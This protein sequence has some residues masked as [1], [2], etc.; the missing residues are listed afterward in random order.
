MRNSKKDR[1]F[2]ESFWAPF[3]IAL[4]CT[5]LIMIRTQRVLPGHPDFDKPEDHHKYI[6]MAQKGPFQFHIAPY[7]WRV[8]VPL[9]A[10]WLPFELSSN[11]SAIS[12]FGVWSAGVGIWYLVKA[13]GYG[14]ALRFFALFLYY[15]I[16][17]S[18]RFPIMDPW[19]P[20][21]LAMGV[22][23]WALVCLLTG[24]Y[25]LLV[26]LLMLGASI[27]ESTIF[28]APLCFTF[29]PRATCRMRD[30]A[31]NTLTFLPAIL[32]LIVLRLAIPAYNADANYREAV[33]PRLYEVDNP[34][35]TGISP[36]INKSY[37][38]LTRLRLIG[39][40]R[41][42][43]LSIYTV[44]ELTVGTF[45]LLPV[46]LILWKLGSQMQLLA[47]WSPFLLC[48]YSQILFATETMRLLAIAFP[49]IIVLSLSGALA[50]AH[51]LRVPMHYLN[52]LP[53]AIFSLSLIWQ[54]RI[55][56]R[57][58]WQAIGIVTSLVVVLVLGRLASRQSVKCANMSH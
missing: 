32:V 29:G 17:P 49:A 51:K 24:R 39:E 5:T 11:F 20:D 33:S 30:I 55:V 53:L 28:V 10:S 35:A 26:V 58:R 43:T 13:I 14:A 41:L 25:L 37:D 45:G 40:Y 9:L 18:C 1:R 57:I 7:C 31:L 38:Y 23:T 42:R 56:A 47:R 8:T 2:F 12:F 3:I 36:E 15:S 22:L 27:K 16:S 21:G 4:I 52:L 48:V 6:H 34:I 44:P 50:L 19:L 46:A 54:D